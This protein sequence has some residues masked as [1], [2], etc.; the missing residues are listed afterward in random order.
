MVRVCDGLSAEEAIAVHNAVEWYVSPDHTGDWMHRQAGV[1]AGLES[2]KGKPWLV[3]GPWRFM[4]ASCGTST[5]MLTRVQ[6]VAHDAVPEVIALVE[7]GLFS[8]RAADK[9][10][11]LSQ[12][13]QRSIAKAVRDEGITDSRIAAR[14][15]RRFEPRKARPV[16][17][18]VL[19]LET[20][21]EAVG[22]GKVS[23]AVQEALRLQA[24][25]G[26]LVRAACL[27]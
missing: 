22:D 3:D 8:I 24:A 18:L 20:L 23:V 25:A 15:I 17:E 12:E 11:K 6:R 13:K 2:S 27:R 4:A 16:P 21:V 26:D 10:A 7:E 5:V 1:Y 19:D 9:A 14:V